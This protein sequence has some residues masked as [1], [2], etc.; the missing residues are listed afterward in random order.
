MAKLKEL[1]ETAFRLEDVF[2]DECEKAN[3][4]KWTW[5]RARAAIAGHIG[6]K[7]DD[8]SRDVELSGNEAIKSAHDNYIKALHVF[9]RARD[10]EGGVLGGLNAN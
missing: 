4:D 9:Y 2:E 8:T 10:G 5:Y 3:C 1:R 7:N 6:R